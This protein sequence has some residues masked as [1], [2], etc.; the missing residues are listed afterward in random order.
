MIITD[1]TLAAAIVLGKAHGSDGGFRDALPWVKF[2]AAWWAY[3]TAFG[4]ETRAYIARQE[5]IAL[6]QAAQESMHRI[7]GWAQV[8]RAI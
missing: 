2:G 5:E 3:E 7:T 4:K 1:A 6:T 8:A